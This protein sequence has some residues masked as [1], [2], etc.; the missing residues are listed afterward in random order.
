[1]GESRQ[2]VGCLLLWLLTLTSARVQGLTQ[3]KCSVKWLTQGEV[4]A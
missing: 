2:M 3:S 1:M 4:Q